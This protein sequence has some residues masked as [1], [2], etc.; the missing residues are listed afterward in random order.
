MLNNLL[1]KFHPLIAFVVANQKN[2]MSHPLLRESGILAL[3][4]YMSVSHALCET[5]LPLLFTAI[6]V[7]K[8]PSMRTTLLICIG[9]LAFRFPNAL[10]PWTARM[11][12]RLSDENE[13]VRY[14]TLT[15]LTHLV[16]NDMIKVKGQVSHVVICL[17]DT[18]P[19]IR[20]LATVFF[21]RL[22]E[23]S[24]NP[25]Y[26]LLGDII[27]TLS[28]DQLEASEKSA[29]GTAIAD[30]SDIASATEKMAELNME[31]SSSSHVS[32]EEPVDENDIVVPVAAVAMDASSLPSR[33]LS[34]AEFETTMKFLLGFVKKDK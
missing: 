15:V 27:A 33:Q 23:R 31:S 5:Y 32:G 1:G 18:C 14:N 16:L 12:S 30:P 17:N 7:E 26:N 2:T 22:S 24:N 25:V 28:R 8:E 10:E 4:R 6:E 21:T 29:E 11:Y 20:D 9:D 13:T 19:Q 3:C 34:K